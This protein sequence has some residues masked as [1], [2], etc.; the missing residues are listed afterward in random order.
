MNLAW[1]NLVQ[2]RTRLG[3]SAAGVALAIM[4]ILILTGFI[5]GLELQ[6]SRYLDN[7]PGSVVLVQADTRGTSSVVP[8]NTLPA[9]TV[10]A[11]RSVP[12][13]ARAVP[14]ISQ[15]AVLDLGQT[16]QFVV[17]IGYDPAL[18]GGP[19][20]LGQ[21][22]LPQSD[23][24]VVLDGVLA[25]RRGVRLNDTFGL[26]G[27][28][29]KVVGLSEGTTT[30]MT[31]YLF[32]RLGAAQ[33]LYASPA[34]VTMVL[35]T[36]AAGVSSEELR[37]RLQGI[38]GA[39]AKLKSD[40]IAGT[41]SFYMSALGAP[42]QLM[43]GIASLVGTLVVGIVI[44]TATLERQREYGVLKAVGARNR[45]LYRVVATQALAAALTG[46][47]LGVVAALGAAWL[48]MTL[49]PQFLITVEPASGLLA[50]TAGLA[51]ALLAALF[52]A[53]LL[54]RLA[55]AEVFRR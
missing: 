4:L 10:D 28:T 8:T 9:G 1:R 29:F 20:D 35:V 34:T 22:R 5:S 39:D 12:G 53:R 17:V 40:L 38:P 24:E 43:A 45:F 18:G 54:A 46:S 42:L 11:A 2:D 25:G 13:V 16:K 6:V 32:M 36:P 14:V 30:W 3:L 23:D 33:R 27:Q 55:P 51:M 26:M 21:G 15:Y 41:R 7:A 44:Y 37:S 52:P 47:A 19:W 31:S 49:R 50:L 48:I